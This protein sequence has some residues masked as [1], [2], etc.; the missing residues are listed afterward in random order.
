MEYFLHETGILVPVSLICGTVL[1]G[2]QLSPDIG[3]GSWVET[4]QGLEKSF[5]PD[6]LKNSH[7]KGYLNSLNCLHH[8]NI[9]FIKSFTTGMFVLL[10]L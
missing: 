8:L 10:K 6:T 5:I 7:A 9:F 2:H 3:S 1:K 4:H